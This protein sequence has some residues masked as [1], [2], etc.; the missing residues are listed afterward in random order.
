[1]WAEVLSSALDS[2]RDLDL[3]L[4][5]QIDLGYTAR[6]EHPEETHPE[7]GRTFQAHKA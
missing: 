1:M 3:C 6:V 2:F 7:I 4:V 5:R